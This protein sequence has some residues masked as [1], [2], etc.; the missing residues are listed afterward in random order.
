MISTNGSTWERPTQLTVAESLF[1]LTFSEGRFFAVS[2]G[3]RLNDSFQ[4]QIFSSRD[5]T[6]WDRLFETNALPLHKVTYGAG[7]AVAIGGHNH[8]YLGYPVVASSAN[9][10]DWSYQRLTNWGRGAFW[11]VAFGGG[12]F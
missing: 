11:G 10:S 1:G 6:Q 12:V 2:Q 3:V 4:T 9:L 8:P 5:G 7:R